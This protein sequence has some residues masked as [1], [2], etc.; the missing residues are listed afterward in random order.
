MKS[1]KNT[2]IRT[3]AIAI[4]SLVPISINANDVFVSGKIPN[5][6]TNYSIKD[7]HGHTLGE[8]KSDG[9]GY[10]ASPITITGKQ[11]IFFE[12]NNQIEK[13]YYD[14]RMLIVFDIKS[15]EPQ[16]LRGG[17][18]KS[19]LK[20]AGG[21]LMKDVAKA[22]VKQAIIAIPGA[23]KAIKDVPVIGGM[24]DDFLGLSPSEESEK[25]DELSDKVDIIDNKI[26]VIDG[27]LVVMDGKL[28]NLDIKM[29]ELDG[30][31]EIVNGKIVVIDK[32]LDNLDIKIDGLD[33][34]ID[35]LHVKIDVI[36]ENIDDLQKTVN[37]L[38]NVM[39][40][41]FAAIQAYNNIKELHIMQAYIR[42]YI[43]L[44]QIL[45]NQLSNSFHDDFWTEEK[46]MK[47]FSGKSNFFT[48][49]EI[50]REFFK[51]LSA[52]E[53][54]NSKGGR[55]NEPMSVCYVLDKYY[56][57][58]NPSDLLASFS[59]MATALKGLNTTDSI[60][61]QRM[62]KKV[63]KNNLTKDKYEID[64]RALK[65]THGEYSTSLYESY[66]FYV[67]ALYYWRAI[68]KIFHAAEWGTKYTSFSQVED[69]F[70]RANKDLKKSFL[71]HLGNGFPNISTCYFPAKDDDKSGFFAVEFL[72]TNKE[73]AKEIDN[74]PMLKIQNKTMSLAEVLRSDKTNWLYTPKYRLDSDESIKEPIG[75]LFNRLTSAL[76]LLNSK[77]YNTIVAAHLNDKGN[78]VVGFKDMKS[79]MPIEHN[80]IL[81]QDEL[82]G[83][84][85]PNG[86]Q[87][88]QNYTNYGGRLHPE[89]INKIPFK[90]ENIESIIDT[91]SVDS[92]RGQQLVEYN[93]KTKTGV[94]NIKFN[95]HNRLMKIPDSRYVRVSD[96]FGTIYTIKIIK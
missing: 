1:R 34:K 48:S 77:F 51:E 39:E 12:Y 79:F 17:T 78:L 10:V 38:C 85:F 37:G 25:L 46:A 96:Q 2:L 52:F 13:I 21:S 54:E 32:K 28:D 5:I 45:Q 43:D 36:T 7:K 60:Y 59:E 16:L 65:L 19:I 82:K 33:M 67:Q 74:A 42:N 15:T 4:I 88:K 26:T 9:K 70:N 91:G 24:L 3:I 49:N 58:K 29:D 31:I 40:A 35:G 80:L 61:S 76:F 62:F 63:F 92:P 95:M 27:K 6:D 81:I 94:L 83:I 30:K 73:M 20:R 11:E 84:T 57:K 22:G 90:G 53:E 89:Y 44:L 87:Y 55:I 93:D 75:H 8:G 50:Q 23:T 72:D 14:G 68:E 56:F 18:G 47:Y 69:H 64:E 41:N 86:K 66:L 71:H